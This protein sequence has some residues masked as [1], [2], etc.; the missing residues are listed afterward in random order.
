MVAPAWVVQHPHSARVRDATNRAH[1]IST[2]RCDL[3]TLTRNTVETAI[4]GAGELTVYA[5][6]TPLQTRAFALL[7]TSPER[8]R[9]E[10]ALRREARAK[11]TICVSPT[12]EARV[13]A[14]H[15]TQGGC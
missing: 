5:R 12:K 10:T 3:A 15:Y 13:S 8:T 7:G 6:P 11:S 1:G 4:A 9:S 2:Q 14:L